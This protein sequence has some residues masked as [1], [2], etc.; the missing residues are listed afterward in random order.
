MSKR[1]TEKRTLALKLRSY[2]SKGLSDVL[3]RYA[4]LLVFL[5]IVVALSLSSPVFFTTR[6]LLN[7]LLQTSINGIIA[8]GM[9]FVIIAGGID[10]SVGAIVALSAVVAT[11]IAHPGQSAFLAL[12]IGVGTGGICGLVNGIVVGVWAVAPFIVTLAMMTILRGIAL[13]YTNGSPVIN[14]SDQFNSI[15]GGHIFFILPAPVF[16]F[17]LV[18]LLGLFVLKFTRLGRYVY[19]V[20]GNELSAK[21]SGVS[22]RF[23]ISL[24]FVISGILSGLAGVILA[25]RVTSGSPVAGTGYELDAIAAVVI[26]GTSLSG[27][28]GSVF[29]TFIGALIIGVINNGLDLIN[30]SSYYQ[31]IVKGLVIFLVVLL[32]K[33]MNRNRT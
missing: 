13:V 29:G 21:V 33:R 15:G 6:N 10:L 5:S 25:S 18:I 26:G 3:R 16:A 9:T 30:V 19:A 28:I 11:S 23:V 24:T 20:G 14:L 22:T 1:T 4:L 31:Q 7:I 32:D 17:L 12:L 8:V 2:Q 27:G